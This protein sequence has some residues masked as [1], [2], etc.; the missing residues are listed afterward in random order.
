MSNI[1]LVDDINNISKEA[2]ASLFEQ[3]IVRFNKK[4]I[5]Y[6]RLNNKKHE[7][8]EYPYLSQIEK[9][10]TIKRYASSTETAKATRLLIVDY[11]DFGRFALNNP[12]IEL[13]GTKYDPFI[14][15]RCIIEKPDFS[16][17]C[18]KIAFGIVLQKIKPDYYEEIKNELSVIVRNIDIIKDVSDLSTDDFDKIYTIKGFI[19]ARDLKT[20]NILVKCVWDC[21]CGYWTETLDMLDK[22]TRCN[23]CKEKNTFKLN[24]ER[25]VIK[26][27]M[28]FTLQQRADNTGEGLPPSIQCKIIGDEL[29]SIFSTN[30]SPGVLVRVTGIPRVDFSKQTISDKEI[31]VIFVE[32]ERDEVAYEFDSAIDAYVKQM[33]ANIV[34]HFNKICRS[35][36]PSLLGHEPIKI[37]IAL[38][39]AGAEPEIQPDGSRLKGDTSILLIGDPAQ[40][41]SVFLKWAS[42]VLPKSTYLA[43]SSTAVGWT[44]GL[45]IPKGKDQATTIIYGA[46]PLSNGGLCCLDEIDKA[47]D[48]EDYAKLAEGMDDEQKIIFAKGDKIGIP[49]L[50]R[51]RNL[52]AANPKR[53]IGSWD[54]RLSIYEQTDIPTW[55][56]SRY[57]LIFVMVNKTND[58][59]DRAL[60]EHLRKMRRR[61]LLEKDYLNNQKIGFDNDFREPDRNNS[62]EDFFSTQYLRQEFLYLSKTYFPIVDPNSNEFDRI[63][64]YVNS[65]RKINL[66]PLGEDD[67]DSDQPKL[68]TSP[69]DHRKIRALCNLA[70]GSARLH[71]RNIV[72]SED[73]DLAISLMDY[74]I[75][76]YM[77]KTTDNNEYNSSFS[78]SE[79]N[80]LGKYMIKEHNKMTKEI[81]KTVEKKIKNVIR[82]MHKY[83]KQKCLDCKDMSPAEL[84]PNCKN[85]KYYY[86]DF[87][88]DTLAG[89]VTDVVLEGIRIN[90]TEFSK[91]FKTFLSSGIVE[92]T[93]AKGNIM[94]YKIKKDFTDD[95]TISEIIQ[96][97]AKT[98]LGT[99]E[100]NLNQNVKI[101][102][103]TAA[104]VEALDWIDR[105]MVRLNLFKNKSEE[106]EFPDE[107]TLESID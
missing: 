99:V 61:T 9:M 24:K 29:C 87:N 74:S 78:K 104:S 83:C 3:F 86:D 94:Y 93:R 48:K 52:H 59:H 28:Y 77:P 70:K 26:D 84:C 58:A 60:K 92:R 72:N 17:S 19:P 76:S 64:D 80:A 95:L 31:D 53:T 45:Y 7:E 82:L 23:Q 96:I 8:I 101:E 4:I 75:M 6:D 15:S 65:R 5:K 106:D 13:L 42:K 10:P 35:I 90:K 39:L 22:P 85:L 2:L 49:I 97:M 43:N 38:M 81:S 34:S 18:F 32:Q 91:I 89:Y 27:F 11:E 40:G 50:T 100:S 105:D 67:A 41:K 103:K 51:C 57:D 36:A 107:N 21:N 63:V 71:R 25:S 16:L 69:V 37:A 79:A 44:A 33:P 66:I 56:F 1:L 46:L 54:P 12:E 14:L 55:L 68:T 30:V 88:Y 73:V 20:R 102:P 47:K 98:I 62:T